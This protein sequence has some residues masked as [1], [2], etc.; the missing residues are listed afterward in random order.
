MILAI[1]AVG[2]MLLSFDR[3][4]SSIG[5]FLGQD[6]FMDGLTGK[7]LEYIICMEPAYTKVW[8][9]S[10]VTYVYLTLSYIIF[11]YMIWYISNVTCVY[12][13]VSYIFCIYIYALVYIKCKLR[14]P[15]SRALTTAWS[16]EPNEM[17]H[18]TM[19]DIKLFH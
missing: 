10:S 8:F 2:E 19:L 14:I 6:P 17:A 7:A 13:T 4:V 18:Y 11:I 1:Q 5:V 15:G 3:I 12:L 9:I 16:V